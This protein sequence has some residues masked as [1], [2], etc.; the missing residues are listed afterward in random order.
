MD[1]STISDFISGI[2]NYI[3]NGIEILIS[4]LG[5]IFIEFPLFIFNMLLGLPEPFFVIIT[6][7]ITIFIGI[8][9]L[10]IV[11]LIPFL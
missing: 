6:G 1:L 4:F 8:M 9:V 5:F 11:K 10:K 7:G 2:T 3:F